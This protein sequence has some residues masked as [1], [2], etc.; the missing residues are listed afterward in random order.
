MRISL[1]WLSEF[2]DIGGLAPH[3]IAEALTASGLEV[4]HVE[5]VGAAFSGVVVGKVLGVEPHPNADKLRLVT[6]D[7]GQSQAKVV[8]GAPNVREGIRIAFAQEGAQVLNRKDGTLFTLGKAKIRGVESAGMVCSIDELGLE[9]LYEKTEDGIWPIDAY[10]TDAQLGQD[11][12][13]ALKLKADAVLEVAPTANRG[14]LMSMVGVAREVAALF[15]R[16]FYSMETPRFNPAPE[17]SELYVNLQDAAVCRYY[18]GVMMR[19]VKIG[20]SPDWMVR[21]LQAAGVRSINNV[22][23]ITNYVMLETGQPLHAFD[24]IKLNTSG[25][26]DVRRAREGEKLVTLD[27]VERKLTPE[28]VV[29]TMN[30]RPVALGGVMGGYNTE[31]DDYTKHLF[32]ESAY[33]PPAV[34]RKS[35][36]SVG[37]RTEASARFE[38]G[39]DLENCRNALLRAAD[40]LKSLA[41]ADFVRLVESPAPKLEKPVVSL[42]FARIEKILGLP[43]ER[44]TVARILKKLGFLLH[45]TRETASIQVAIPSF[46]QGDVSREIDLIEEVIRIYGYDKVP[47]TLPHKTASVSRTLRA[48]LLNRIAAAMRGQGMQEV[49]TTSLIGDSLLQKTGFSVNPD[50]LVTVVNSHS[51]DHTL[52]RQSLLPN[53]IEVAKFNQAQGVED[54]WIYELGRTYFKLGKPN[55]K[56]SGVSE[57]LHL[58]GLITGSRRCGEWH[59]QE[60]PDFF[61]LKG[62]LENLL[63]ALNLSDVTFRR[64]QETTCLHPGKSAVIALDGGQKEL[65]L[66]GELH[67]ERQAALKLR[68]PVYVFELNVETLY[69]VLKQQAQPAGEVI[70]ISPYPAVKRDMA[71]LAPDALSHADIVNALAAVSDPTLKAVELFDEYRSEQ[72][73]ADKRSLAYRLTFQSDA[74]TLTDARIEASMQA[75]K[76]ALGRQHPVQFR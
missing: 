51:S 54:V 60:T 9:A 28:A 40:L 47:Y 2:V 22:V 37:L 56:N 13:E 20:P 49:V 4:E 53:L 17:R 46:R 33:F 5:T 27:E 71:F 36:K 12:K 45:P 58:A 55:A 21:R 52:M 70:R 74:E 31:I 23:D 69:K 50:E 10:V 48:R 43:I 39:V 38:R 6:V 26:L 73:G 30:D 11:L 42:R 14:D 75:L 76:E 32:L 19:N 16:P 3:A 24:Q 67:P 41:G 72:L 8:C 18:G 7:L 1:E 59:A 34:I 61:L 29:V 63:G 65:G 62:V 25:E 15:D 35:A 66:I 64:P 44:E 68:H 57:K